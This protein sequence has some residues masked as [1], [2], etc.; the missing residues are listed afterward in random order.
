M[1]LSRSGPSISLAIYLH[2]ILDSIFCDGRLIDDRNMMDFTCM[3]KHANVLLRSLL[4]WKENRTKKKQIPIQIAANCVL[5]FIW[6]GN[7]RF[8]TDKCEIEIDIP[9]RNHSTHEIINANN[10]FPALLFAIV[11]MQ[12]KTRATRT[13]G[14]GSIFIASSFF[15]LRSLIISMGD[16]NGMT[17]SVETGQTSISEMLVQYFGLEV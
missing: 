10:W 3:C 11:S 14:G 2:I 7:W 4:V 16:F 13:K 17:D 12:L 5:L 15:K 6:T 9:N 8:M 1:M